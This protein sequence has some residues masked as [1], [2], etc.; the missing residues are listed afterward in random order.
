MAINLNQMPYYDDYDPSKKYVQMLALPGRVEQARE[1]T[2]IQTMF[3][4]FL[5]RGLDVFL[6]DGDIVEGCILTIDGTTAHISE[7]KIYLN[8][9]IH[10][11]AQTEITIT[12]VGAEVI[13]AK[14]IETIVTEA[15]DPSLRDPAQGHD[16]YQ[17]PGAHRLKQEVE[18]VLNDP[19]AVPV[20]RLHDGNILNKEATP[21][22]DVLMEVLARRTYDESGNY[23][24]DGFQMSASNFDD[25]KVSLNIEKGKAYV[26]GYEVTKP[27]A[28]RVLLDKSLD[29]RTVLSEPKVYTNGTN[30]YKL[31]NAPVKQVNRVVAVVQVTETIT[32]GNIGGG[33]DFLPKKPVV[34]IVSVTQGATTFVR[35]TDYQLTADG[36]DWSLPGQEPAIGTTYTVT[37]KYNKQM[38]PNTDY[39]LT[40]QNGNYYIDFSPD[41]DNPVNGTTF[42]VDYDFYLARIDVISLDKDGNF[43]VTK[44]QP[45]IERLVKAPI[46]ENPYI[47]PLASV[48]LPPN[49][50]NVTITEF[51]NKRISYQDIYAILKR[52]EDLEYNQAIDALDQEAMK[53][54][55]PTNLKG[56]FSEGFIGLSRADLTHPN[57][58]ATIDFTKGELVLPTTPTPNKLLVDGSGT[59]GKIMSRL[60]LADFTKEVAISQPYATG[61]MLINPYQVYK[62]TGQVT[63]NPAVDRWVDTENIMVNTNS[64][65]QSEVVTTNVRRLPWWQIYA[66]GLQ[67]GVASSTITN[68]KKTTETTVSTKVILDEAVSYMR[69][70]VVT[71]RGEG[72][73]PNS[74]N[75]EC[76]FDGKKVLL[77]GI[78][79]TQQGTVEGTVKVREDG[80][81]EAQFTIPSNIRTG[82]KEVVFRND[83]ATAVT[84]FTSEGRYK[85]LQTTINTH[86][87]TTVFRTQTVIE[88]YDPLAQSFSFSED[89][90]LTSIGVFFATKDPN[91]PI[92]VQIRNME[93][94]LPGKTILASKVLKP[95]QIQV[96]AN[97]T[98]ETVVDFDEPIFIKGGEAYAIVLVTTSPL[99]SVYVAELGKKDLVSNQFV[100]KQP[101]TVGVL[102]SSSNGTS[103]TIH[104]S[105]DM[106]FKVY[107]ARFDTTKQ[108][109]IT[110]APITG[111]SADAYLAVADVMTPTDTTVRWEVKIG[112][113]DWLPTT[114]F[115]KIDIGSI[116]SSIQLRAKLTPTVYTSPVIALDSATLISIV[117]ATSATYISKQITLP[118]PATTLK[119][120]VELSLP[121]GASAIV[122]YTTDGTTW[123]NA[124]QTGTE[125]V[126][127]NFT[128]YTF[129]SNISPS[130]TT[131]RVRIDLSVNNPTIRAKARKFLNIMK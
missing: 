90:I 94:G 24:V 69:S 42:N 107:T 122:K 22:L 88:G 62:K 43:V 49:S 125:P 75:V 5:K 19:T 31:N 63:L 114:L 85:V 32:R 120:V 25:T 58:D 128:R 51:L 6:R 10:P 117:T 68:T 14:L 67:A 78:N 96:S 17:Q 105:H 56:I 109:V 91:E 37:Y 108:H 95:D 57:Y 29:T 104:Q 89:R 4:D 123:V 47:L 77:Q 54:E 64:S 66:S 73:Y 70:I 131:F 98:F 35:G 11:V 111:L 126:D 23:R 110:F 100:A 82:T 9:L 13:G 99:Y 84:T 38:V 79:G 34:E 106:K 87:H 27:Y 40:V 15:D 12:G 53:G 41:G 30:L 65:S 86:T 119:Q 39:V 48:K 71:A 61:T 52:L 112:N 46:V 7:G 74:D 26:L 55:S 97:G 59:T 20:F 44:G 113:G 103:W 118:T 124:T 36:V 60:A 72:F 92:T 3:R 45:D 33:V 115:E 129:T 28:S 50:A 102:F 16:N 101:Y 130:A 81:F 8:G 93:A 127:E 80:T 21:Q 18:L 121:S 2:Q 116:A 83:L 1:F 76:L